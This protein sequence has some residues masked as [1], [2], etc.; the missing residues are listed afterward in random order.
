MVKQNK[1]KDGKITLDA[2]SFKKMADPLWKHHDHEDEKQLDENDFNF[3]CKDVIGL[4]IEKNSLTDDHYE[5]LNSIL[6][7]N[8]DE[9]FQKYDRDGNLNIPYESFFSFFED[10]VG[11]YNQSNSHGLME[12]EPEVTNGFFTAKSLKKQLEK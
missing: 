7:D 2:I 10:V 1:S 11:K 9:F 3:V 6:D 5:L 4:L 12:P 8:F